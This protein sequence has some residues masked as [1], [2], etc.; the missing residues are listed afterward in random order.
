MLVQFTFCREKLFTEFAM[1]KHVVLISAMFSQI[2]ESCVRS[3]TNGTTMWLKFFVN[4]V[5]VAINFV[6]GAF[7]KFETDG[8]LMTITVIT[9]L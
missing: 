4:G 1:F 6:K 3:F 7:E 2:F 5:D 8:T 9:F